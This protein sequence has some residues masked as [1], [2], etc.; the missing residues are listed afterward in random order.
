M[1]RKFLILMFMLVVGYSLLKFTNTGNYD[2]WRLILVNNEHSIPYGYKPEL[3]QLSNGV[4][5]DEK[6]YPYLQRMFD[7][8]RSDG[9]YPVV[10]EGYRTHEEQKKMMS[11]KVE[12]FI[13]EGYSER[14]AKKLAREWVAVAGKSEHEIGL[15]LDINADQSQSTDTEVYDWLA[16]NAYKYGFI[17][18]YPP[19][20]EYITGIDYEPWHYRYVGTETSAEIHARNITLEEYLN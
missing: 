15:A 19:D 4:Q 13:S 1:K 3:M 2:D 7:D 11:D 6:I 17:L 18:R 14:D 12:S 5:I 8:M 9:I 16:E 20:K 10:S